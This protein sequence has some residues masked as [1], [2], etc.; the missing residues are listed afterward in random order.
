MEILAEGREGY[1]MGSG[2]MKKY[3]SILSLTHD[4]DEECSNFV[5]T[6]LLMS[7]CVHVCLLAYANNFLLA[8]YFYFIYILLKIKF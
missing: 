6:F 2:R 8:P 5:Y 4:R 3:L 7:V 1:E